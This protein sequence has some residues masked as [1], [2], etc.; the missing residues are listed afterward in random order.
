MANVFGRLNLG[1]TAPGENPN[2]FVAQN[3]Q[4]TFVNNQA[5][6]I[7]DFVWGLPADGA[8]WNKTGPR[9]EGRM[10]DRGVPRPMA[11]SVRRRG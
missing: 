5:P 11:I 9:D 8:R 7:D 2:G 1:K 4:G 3:P 6:E 10:Q